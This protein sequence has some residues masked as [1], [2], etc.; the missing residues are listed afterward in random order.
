MEIQ[1]SLA[2]A[3]RTPLGMLGGCLKK[4]RKDGKDYRKKKEAK[5]GYVEEEMEG[6]WGENE[7]YLGSYL[8]EDGKLEV[9]TQT[10]GQPIGIFLLPSGRQRLGK[11][12]RKLGGGENQRQYLCVLS[13]SGSR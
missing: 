3:E 1:K 5:G 12:G 6:P 10:G 11:K 9:Y 4:E 8:N 13:P 7:S 2:H